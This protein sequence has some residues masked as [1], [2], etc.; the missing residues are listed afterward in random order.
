M[1]PNFN[2]AMKFVI[3]NISSTTII[4]DLAYKDN[5]YMHLSNPLLK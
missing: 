2:G 4:L 1:T 5:I 3:I